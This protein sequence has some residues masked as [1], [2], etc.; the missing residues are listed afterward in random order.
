MAYDKRMDSLPLFISYPRTGAHWINSVMELYFDRPR[1]REG[2]P[3][4]LDRSRTDWMWF[5]DHDLDLQI[6]HTNVL[7]MYRE[8]V[9]TIYSYLVH[10]SVGHQ[11]AEK[12]IFWNK[13]FKYLLKL[14]SPLKSLGFCKPDS[15]ILRLYTRKNMVF[16]EENVIRFSEEYRE[17]LKKW[18][19]SDQKA[20]TIVCYDC[21]KEDRDAEFEKICQHFE[22]EF[23][24]NRVSWAFGIVSK[25]AL[26]KLS[27]NTVPMGCHMLAT[28]YRTNREKFFQAW[29]NLVR[30]TVIIPGLK[31][32]FAGTGEN[33]TQRI[34]GSSDGSCR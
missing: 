3:T 31:P 18:I 16:N 30:E 34:R 24:P 28:K 26:V 23:D 9:A 8:P 12:E 1:L 11:P 19:L 29:G 22:L 20:R 15:K 5:H 13:S 2:R 27:D 6:K 14:W 25:E 33:D 4:F 21:F 17:N 10:Q 32:F 7:Y